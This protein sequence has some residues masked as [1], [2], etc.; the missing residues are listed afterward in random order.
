MRQSKLY[1]ELITPES[2]E[3]MTNKY[4]FKGHLG[5]QDFFTLIGME[6]EDLF[7]ILPCNWNRQ[8]CT[9]CKY[10][11]DSIISSFKIILFRNSLLLF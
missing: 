6:H 11:P 10:F 5:D 3:K 1:S 9:W 7:H 8:L 2:V 4:H